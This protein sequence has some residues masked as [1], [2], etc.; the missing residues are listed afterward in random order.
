MASSTL[1]LI[2]GSTIAPVSVDDIIGTSGASPVLTESRVADSDSIAPRAATAS[3]DLATVAMMLPPLGDF[4]PV[5]DR[6]SR[7]KLQSAAETGLAEAARDTSTSVGKY[8][9]DPKHQALVAG[10]IGAFAAVQALPGL[11]GATDA[12][13]GAVGAAM[14]ASVGPEH[15]ANIE[16]ALGEFKQYATGAVGATSPSDL[17]AAAHHFAAFLE[18]GG[19]EAADALGT[20]AAAPL[21]LGG[22]AGKAAALSDDALSAG[23]KGLTNA[24]AAAQ[25]GVDAANHWLGEAASSL[26]PAGRPALAPAGA[27]SDVGTGMLESRGTRQASQEASS[28]RAEATAT[29]R[30][31]VVDNDVAGGHTVSRHV[32]I[33]KA[34][35][36][37]RLDSDPKLKAASSF[38]N[39]ATANFAQTTLVKQNRSA[40]DHWLKSSETDPLTIEAD[41]GKP[42]GRVLERDGRFTE[43][44]KVRGIAV[45]DTSPQGWHFHSSFPIK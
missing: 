7:A 12:A 33:S 44:T 6:S 30:R 45:K 37:D 26:A 2:S 24:G 29:D 19:P 3:P 38:P 9:G 31:N 25:R 8:L 4:G 16:K 15:K 41:T 21:K 36:Q 43:A 32:K 17:H 11:D 28:T 35:L 1:G 14:Y 22:I 23:A 40:I 10:G 34:S 39:L 13:V 18:I 5:A 20:L 42:V 27:G